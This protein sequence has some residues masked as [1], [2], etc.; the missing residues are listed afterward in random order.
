MTDAEIIELLGGIT[1]VARYFDIKPPSVSGWIETGIPEVRLMA[2]APQLELRSNG[3]FTRKARWPESYAFF[4]PELAAAQAE[5]APAAAD[6]IAVIESKMTEFK[7][8]LL[9]AAEDELHQVATGAQ[10]DLKHAALEVRGD[11]GKEAHDAME[12][13]AP[14]TKP[15]NGEDRRAGAPAAALPWDGKERRRQADRRHPDVLEAPE[16]LKS[17]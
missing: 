15:W 12:R 2:L 7:D 8:Q 5:P 6:L 1:V 13:L 10:V 16:S 14:P 11:I 9:H 4:W 17:A 3:R